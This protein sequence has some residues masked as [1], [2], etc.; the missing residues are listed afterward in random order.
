M[1]HIRLFLSLI[2]SWF[3]FWFTKV[4][5]C[6]VFGRFNNASKCVFHIA[7]FSVAPP[8][9]DGSMGFLLPCVMFCQ[10]VCGKWSWKTLACLPALHFSF[11]PWQNLDASLKSVCLYFHIFKQ[12]SYLVH[13]IVFS[14][15]ISTYFSHTATSHQGSFLTCFRD[16]IWV[17]RIKENYHQVPRIRE[18]QVPRIRE[19]GPYRSIPGT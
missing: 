8:I 2:L 9:D 17:H 18:N 14:A 7:E 15:K 5:I 11:A 13:M 1:F 6:L 12:W 19:S 16:Q 10:N 4:P 3:R